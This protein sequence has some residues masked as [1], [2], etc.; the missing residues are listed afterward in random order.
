MDLEQMKALFASLQTCEAWSLQLLK[1]NISKQSKTTYIGR[2]I[3]LSPDG[4][5]TSFVNELSG[6]YRDDGRGALSAYQNIV[7][8]DGSTV[9][10]VIYRLDGSNSLIAEEYDAL[11]AAIADP[12]TELDPLEFKARAYV[13]SGVV[14]PGGEEKPVKLISMQN[15]MTSLKHRFLGANGTFKEI[16]D[17]VL[18][19]RMSIDV[20]I[21]DGTVYML[22]L[23][24]ENLFNME[25]AYKAVCAEKLDEIERCRIVSDFASFSAIA[26]G[27]HNPRRFASFNETHLQKLRNPLSRTEVA[28]KFGIPMDGDLFDSTKPGVADKIVKLLCNRGMIDPFDN[29]PMEVAG[30]KKWE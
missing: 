3:T 10:K 21:V 25:R 5:L 26:G 29:N 20:V 11:I 22:S 17:K 6:H 19:L 1:I 14:I 8:Y 23:A 7:E 4:T 30:S 28:E 9:D 13:L 24:G 27:G 12:D 18:T 15:P 2:E 16:S